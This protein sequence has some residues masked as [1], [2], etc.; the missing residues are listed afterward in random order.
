MHCL[1]TDHALLLSIIRLLKHTEVHPANLWRKI[2]LRA[3]FERKIESTWFWMHGDLLHSNKQD[4]IPIHFITMCS[5]W[6]KTSESK[7]LHL[8]TPTL[9]VQRTCCT[10]RIETSLHAAWDEWTSGMEDV[11]YCII[12]MRIFCSR[13]CTSFCVSRLYILVGTSI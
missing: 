5:D 13:L 1:Q 11:L 6:V 4:F 7:P 10:F 8:Y 2:I 12:F 3:H 9:Y